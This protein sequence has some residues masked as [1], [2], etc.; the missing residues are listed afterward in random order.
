MKTKKNIQSI[1]DPIYV[2]LLLMVE[3]DKRH[4]KLIND[5]NTK[6]ILSKDV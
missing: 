2:D 1:C 6:E 4:Y 3:E 5:F